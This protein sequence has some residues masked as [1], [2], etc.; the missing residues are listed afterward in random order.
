MKFE[1]IDNA[2]PLRHPKAE[3]YGEIY[4]AIYAM[5]EG[6]VL[7]IPFEEG[8]AHGLRNVQMSIHKAA[9]R[10]RVPAVRMW[11]S[12]GALY[13]ARKDMSDE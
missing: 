5:P 2:P 6:Q 11:Q 13:V 12:G 3:A 10:G 1:Y 9:G 4:D 7:R 8:D